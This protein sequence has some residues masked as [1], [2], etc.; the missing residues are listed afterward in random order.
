METEVKILACFHA[1]RDALMANDTD[2][3]DGLMTKGYRAYN[4]RGEL[5]GREL[6][7]ETYGPGTTTLDTWEVSDLQVEV[8]TEI[9][10]LTGKGF[11]AGSWNGQGWSHHL[12]FCDVYVREDGVWRLHLS[13]ATEMDGS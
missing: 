13:Q 11:L 3:L 6:V 5:E 9:G 7:L 10:I 8:F 4:L 2:A 1:F 12:R